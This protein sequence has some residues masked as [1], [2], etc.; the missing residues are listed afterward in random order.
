M[1]ASFVF[2]IERVGR[3]REGGP[4]R[5]RASP[6]DGLRRSAGRRARGPRARAGRTRSTWRAPRAGVPPAAPSEDEHGGHVGEIGD[7]ARTCRRAG[8]PTRSGRSTGSAP[9]SRR[10]RPAG[11]HGV[12][13]SVDR[14][15]PVRGTAVEDPV[16][17]DHARVADVDHRPG[18]VDVQPDAEADEEE[19]RRR[20]HPHGPAGA[21]PRGRDRRA[22]ADPRRARRGG[23]RAAGTASGRALE[24][25]PAVEER[26]RDAEREQHEQIERHAA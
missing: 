13:S 26:E 14:H 1:I 21:P 5:T 2:D 6:R 11:P 16:G 10:R 23:R 4:A 20:E 15:R 25:L 22:E 17:A 24:H 12:R 3:E 9:G 18:A 8:S 7:R 19:R